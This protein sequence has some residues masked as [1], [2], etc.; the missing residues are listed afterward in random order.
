M[1]VQKK[2]PEF[3]IQMTELSENITCGHDT[4]MMPRVTGRV[5]AA[6]P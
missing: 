3:V 2:P 1:T 5:P 4:G 6:K